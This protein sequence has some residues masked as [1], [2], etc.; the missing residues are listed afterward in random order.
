MTTRAVQEVGLTIKRIQTRH[1]RALDARLGELG[2]SLVQWDALR[3][4]NE[5]PDASLRDL[6]QLTFQSDQAFG[7]LATRMI[8]RGL[9]QRVDGPGRAIKHRITDKGA[10]LLEQGSA[11]AEEVLAISFAPLDDDE[12]ATLRELLLR[13]G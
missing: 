10:R 2:L 6:A 4:L 5:N 11:V 13:L 3:H 1:H 8:R 7:T 9:I 12:L